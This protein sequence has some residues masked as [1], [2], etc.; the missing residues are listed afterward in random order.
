MLRAKTIKLL[1]HHQESEKITL[2]MRRTG[3][4]IISEKDLDVENMNFYLKNQKIN[5]HGLFPFFGYCEGC[6]YQHP[7]S[8]WCM[9]ADVVYECVCGFTLFFPCGCTLSSGT[10]G[11]CGDSTSNILR[12]CQNERTH[13]MWSTHTRGY[14]QPARGAERWCSSARLTADEPWKQTAKQ[15]SAQ[16]CMF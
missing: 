12:N 7:H 15:L 14:M 13:K 3:V 4:Q 11:S 6:F 9:S 16:G 8:M 1:E 2:R 10:A 5:G